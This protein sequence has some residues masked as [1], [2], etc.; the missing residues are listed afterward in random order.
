MHLSI[1]CQDE[2]TNFLKSILCQGCRKQIPLTTC[3]KILENTGKTMLMT[4][5]L[6][7]MTQLSEMAQVCQA[8]VKKKKKEDSIHT[9]IVQIN[10]YITI[11]ACI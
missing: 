4:A 11:K 1:A 5:W 9:F 2:C 8:H 7:F 6:G 10:I 3:D